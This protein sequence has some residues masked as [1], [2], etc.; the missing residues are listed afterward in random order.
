MHYFFNLVMKEGGLMSYNPLVNGLGPVGVPRLT[1]SSSK[2][3]A[4]QADALPEENTHCNNVADKQWTNYLYDRFLYWG[5]A[6]YGLID[7]FLAAAVILETL[8]AMIYKVG[9]VMPAPAQLIVTLSLGI[10]AAVVSA[11]TCTVYEYGEVS[12]VVA[13]TKQQEQE[14]EAALAAYISACNQLMS[15][16]IQINLTN[17]HDKLIKKVTGSKNQNGVTKLAEN[18]VSDKTTESVNKSL[19]SLPVMWLEFAIKFSA[20]L[21]FAIGFYLGASM[22]LSLLEK[23]H[24]LG[25][26]AVEAGGGYDLTKYADVIALV[27]SNPIA[28][29]VF[30]ASAL[31]CTCAAYQVY[32]VLDYQSLEEAK[33][34]AKN[35]DTLSTA[36]HKALQ[37]RGLV[38]LKA[39]SQQQ[40]VADNYE[41]MPSLLNA[42]EQQLKQQKEKVSEKKLIAYLAM[43]LSYGF[44]DGFTGMDA[45]AETVGLANFPAMLLSVVLGIVSAL[46]SYA[47]E[48]HKWKKTLAPKNDLSKNESHKNDPK[49]TVKQTADLL[50][51]YQKLRE[52]VYTQLEAYTDTEDDNTGNTLWQQITLLQ[53]VNT[54]LS[55]HYNELSEG[56]NS[57]QSVS[58]SLL[59]TGLSGISAFLAM[60][61]GFFVGAYA[62]TMLFKYASIAAVM[63]TGP[64]GLMILLPLAGTVCAYM[65]LKYHLATERKAL[66]LLFEVMWGGRPEQLCKDIEGLGLKDDQQQFAN[67]YSVAAPTAQR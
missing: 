22:A 43:F 52:Q 63:T 50:A 14:Q 28:A 59:K 58:A 37:W 3:E 5:F 34:Q 18:L 9:G 31:I 42:V 46:V 62:V 19:S 36:Q 7:G 6:L 57:N 2:S 11:Y 26:L 24:F 39:N 60:A 53:Q 10:M 61:G 12:E 20:G 13:Q 56:E 32:K 45:I 65:M 4:H 21:Y 49:E 17:F 8:F 48:Y 54:Q 15:S 27:L 38:L 51:A 25:K 64:L 30:F 44:A 16:N 67:I 55:S 40:I 66:G 41:D 29:S 23:L 47:F 1:V 35:P 33:E